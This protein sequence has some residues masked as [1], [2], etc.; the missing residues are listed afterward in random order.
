MLACLSHSIH[1]SFGHI[2][3]GSC[4][5]CAETISSLK[6]EEIDDDDVPLAQKVQ[7]VVEDDDDDDVP[8]TKKIKA[9]KDDDDM[10]L[11]QKA[12]AVSQ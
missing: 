6:K 1:F 3:I 4:S 2:F 11:S 5:A 8:L 12:K 7:A 9:S 10:P